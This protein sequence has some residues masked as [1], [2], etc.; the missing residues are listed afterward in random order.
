MFGSNPVLNIDRQ[1]EDLQ[2]L[3]AGYQNQQP[4]N[5][6]NNATPNVNDFY[7]RYLGENEKVDEILVTHKTA[8]IDLK[9]G[10]LS[11]KELNGDT[12]CYQLILPKD[13]KDLKIEEL[14]R[15]LASYE[16]VNNANNEVTEPSGNDNVNN[17]TRAKDISKSIS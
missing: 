4:I 6:Y 16:R 9:N 1:I 10:V 12:Q 7:A 11:V 15:R 13:E 8:F 14:E 3:R 2:R 17:D 5:I